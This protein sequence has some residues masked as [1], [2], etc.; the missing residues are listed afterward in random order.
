MRWGPMKMIRAVIR[1]EREGRVLKCLEEAG[2]FA[3]TKFSVRGR[4]MQRGIQVGPV[5]YSEIAKTMLL[6]VVEEADLSTA[7]V[8][9]R[10]GARTGNPG[11]GKIF[12]QEVERVVTVRTGR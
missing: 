5:V 11:D 10:E 9:I 12:V 8:A 4:G 1:P 3:V 2:L 6:L 7:L